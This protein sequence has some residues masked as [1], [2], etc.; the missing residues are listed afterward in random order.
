M[1]VSTDVP[2]VLTA[3]EGEAEVTLRTSLGKCD[4]GR[5]MLREGR[6]IGSCVGSGECTTPCDGLEPSDTSDRV[7]DWGTAD[8]RML[9]DRGVIGSRDSGSTEE[10]PDD[11]GVVDC[12][13]KGAE[14]GRGPGVRGIIEAATRYGAILDP[15]D[16]NLSVADS[17]M[18]FL[19]A[20]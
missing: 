11:K 2:G 13:V 15:S 8:G 3:M 17:L 9:G 19:G 6:E 5:R 7:S 4:G 16:T 20:R 12:S 1:P 14:R 10:H 18:S